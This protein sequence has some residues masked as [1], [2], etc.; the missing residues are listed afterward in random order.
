M[1]DRFWQRLKGIFSPPLFKDDPIRSASARMVH[2]LVWVSI[3]GVVGF[4]M[5]VITSTPGPSW[6]ILLTLLFMAFFLS[7]LLPLWRREIRRASYIYV[8]ALWLLT[9]LTFLGSNGVR[10]PGYV[11]MMNVVLVAGVLLGWREAASVMLVNCL[12]GLGSL[13]IEP[14]NGSFT[15]LIGF[16]MLPSS[17]FSIWAYYVFTFLGATILL[18]YAIGNIYQSLASANA[19]LLERQRV[20]KELRH[21]REMLDLAQQVGGIGHYLVDLETGRMTWSPQ[22]FRIHGF[23]PDA[24]EPDR[25]T[26]LRFIF[27]PDQ[28]GF[29]EHIIYASQKDGF[30]EYECRIRKPDG[31][32]RLVRFS[33]QALD[34]PAGGSPLLILG[35]VQDITDRKKSEQALRQREALLAAIVE[36]I[37]LDLWVC[38][39]SGRYL[40]Q[41]P[42]SLALA[43]NLVGKQVEDLPFTPDLIN[44]F[45]ERHARALAGEVISEEVTYELLGEQRHVLSVHSPII[46][47]GEVL[48]FVGLNVDLTERKKTEEEIKGL[49]EQLEERVRLRTTE[50]QTA[51]RE[52]E[53]FAYS[54]SHDLRAPLRAIQGFAHVLSE[55]YRD[56]LPAEARH[57]LSRVQSNTLHMARLIDD[58]LELS[59][60]ARMEMRRR[61]VDM[62]VLL[63]EAYTSLQSAD[64]SD[65]DVE[66]K[67]VDLPVVQGDPM[68]LRQVWA[69]LLGNALKYTSKQPKA[70]I[71]VGCTTSTSEYTFWVKD[72]GA[73]FDM[74]YAHKLFG[75]FQRLHRAEDYEGT[76]IGLANVKR[77]IQRHGGRVWAEGAVG[78][79]AS[80]YFTL[81]RVVNG[82]TD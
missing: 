28:A 21:S 73:G 37:P 39:A 12:I 8:I 62:G 75:V 42:I 64:A 59:R 5:V 15:N 31:S 47:D 79:G 80:F 13:W 11:N 16:S 71:E 36:N 6:R 2:V 34:A 63:E 54:V 67:V 61:E 17:S 18:R 10:S 22:L 65:L 7:A 74:A 82:D 53:A 50:L 29:E 48:G 49:N 32:L 60:L 66:I 20:E 52:L 78:L 72:N 4:S 68:L 35:T 38:D 24:F 81:P 27:P 55:D 51:N 23:E 25:D 76:G 26:V 40:L 43:G 3:V 56:A 30:G 9:T 44:N 45:K 33:T 77:I 70:R 57:Y 19:E 69:N 58:L 46:D 1:A 14:T 41:T